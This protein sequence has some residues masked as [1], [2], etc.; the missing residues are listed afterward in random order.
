MTSCWFHPEEAD[1]VGTLLDYFKG[2][3]GSTVTVTYKGDESYACKF[4]SSYDADNEAELDEGVET[5]PVDYFAIALDPIKVIKK[6]RHY[7][8][9]GCYIELSYRDFPERIVA[10]D[11]ALI[12][13]G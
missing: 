2:H 9:P 7:G 3:R 6:G 12:Y 13:Q 11:G 5:E 10:E 4:L 1:T 8:M